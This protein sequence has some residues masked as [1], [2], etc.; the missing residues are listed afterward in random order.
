MTA[1]SI[2]KKAAALAALGIALMAPTVSAQVPFDRGMKE[3]TVFVPKNQWITGVSVGYSAE[4]FNN[5]QFLVVEGLKGGGYTFNVSPMCLYAFANDMAAGGRFSYSR[6]LMQLDK[7][8]LTL[9]SDMS[10][11]AEDIYSLSH[12]YGFTCLFRNYIPLGNSKRFGIFN[13]VQLKFAGGQSKLASGTGLALSGTYSENFDLGIG[14]TP[15]VV[16]FLNNFS[17][18]EVNVGVLGFNYHDT[19]MTTDQIYVAN[20]K[21]HS[22][23]FKINLF[24]ITFGTVFYI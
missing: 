1:L 9:S 15:G 8:S 10:F 24:S 6:T 23:N 3:K 14:V 16:M 2:F 4:N 22:A 12:N 19:K 18:I 17:A 11:G 5:Y 21:T 20:M 7:A 13:E